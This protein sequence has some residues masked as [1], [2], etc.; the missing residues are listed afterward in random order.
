MMVMTGGVHAGVGHALTKVV[1]F[2]QDR[3][4]SHSDAAQTRAVRPHAVTPT[5]LLVTRGSL[6]TACKK[7]FSVGR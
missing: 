1:D 3:S 2:R 4:A 6:K 5:A 7:L